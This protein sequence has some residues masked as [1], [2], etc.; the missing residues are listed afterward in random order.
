MNRKPAQFTIFFFTG[1]LHNIDTQTHHSLTL[2]GKTKGKGEV[3]Y[4][5][6][7]NIYKHTVKRKNISKGKKIKKAKRFAWTYY[8]I[9]VSL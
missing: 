2:K 4:Y 7:N 9:I 5:N 3:V 1:Y 6:K 8:I